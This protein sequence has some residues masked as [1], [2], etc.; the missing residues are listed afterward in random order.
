MRYNAALIWEE[1]SQEGGHVPCIDWK[2]L[3]RKLRFAAADVRQLGVVFIE[4]HTRRRQVTA[5]R[6]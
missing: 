3:K 2:M 5:G 6:K 4:V 1:L